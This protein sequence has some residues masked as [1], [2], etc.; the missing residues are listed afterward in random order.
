MKTKNPFSWVLYTPLQNIKEKKKQT[1]KK[2]T[3]E[4]LTIALFV[5]INKSINCEAH[6]LS[7]SCLH[8]GNN[9]CMLT[10]DV[11]SPIFDE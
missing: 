5:S 9:G 6:P 7:K 8:I 4:E 10:L 1:K 11:I 3:E 2:T